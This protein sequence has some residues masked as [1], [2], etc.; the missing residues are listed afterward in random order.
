[1]LKSYIQIILFIIYMFLHIDIINKGLKYV[2]TGNLRIIKKKSRELFNKGSKYKKY[3]NRS[4][5]K[6]ESSINESASIFID[7]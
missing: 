6:A 2:V 5:K 1:M 7:S 4:W 3:N